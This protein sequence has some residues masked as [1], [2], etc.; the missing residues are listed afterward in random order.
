LY[1]GKGVDIHKR[2]IKHFSGEHLSCKQAEMMD[3]ITHI[4][5]HPTTGEL[6]ALLHESEQLR[7][8]S[9]VYNRQRRMMETMYTFMLE[10]AGEYHMVSIEEIEPTEF[11]QKPNY[12]G[13]FKTQRDAE[14]ILDSW[15]ND[16]GLSETMPALEHNLLMVQLL[17]KYKL[18][19]WWFSGPIAVKEYCKTQNRT[20]VHVFDQW[21]FLGTLEPQDGTVELENL[22]PPRFDM[23][24]YKILQRFFRQPRRVNVE[25]MTLS[26]LE[27]FNV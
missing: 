5:F 3:R 18:K 22:N 2:V 7:Q 27:N 1:I 10:T 21:C 24:H 23:D 15:E 6:G 4:D 19:N 17:A 20:Q 13:S 12:Y 9:P 26:S 8:C 14:K 25:V 11:L 16:L